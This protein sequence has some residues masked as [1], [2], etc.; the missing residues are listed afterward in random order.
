MMAPITKL[1]RK[2]VEWEWTTAQEKAFETVKAALT[3]KPLLRYPNFS[4]PFRLATGASAIGLGACLMQDYGQDWQPIAFASK[5]NN[6]VESKYSITELECLAVVWA[7][8]LFRPYLYGRTFTILTDHAALKW[9]M[10]S[11]NLTGKL[12]RWAITL[13]EYEF[14]VQFRPGSTNVVADALSRAPVKMLA[15]VGKRRRRRE[16][17]VI[18]EDESAGTP[19]VT[20]RLNGKSR[21]RYAT[22]R[23]ALK[24]TPDE[25]REV[26]R[27]EV[28][29]EQSTEATEGEAVTGARE[30]PRSPLIRGPRSI[31]RTEEGGIRHTEENE[32]TELRDH[33]L[34]QNFF[35]TRSAVC[36][37]TAT[38]TAYRVTYSTAAMTYRCPPSLMGSEPAT[39]NAH[40]S[41][42]SPPR[43]LRKGGMTSRGRVLRLPHSRH[44]LTDD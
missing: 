41:P 13:Q 36:S 1:L 40:R 7:I 24:K 18:N 2:S 31:Q 32:Y 43:R 30:L 11:N 19:K 9:L 25:S 37:S 35:A 16:Q 34:H 28:E 5:V 15:A 23:E 21:K 22:R 10:T 26:Q 39:S 17:V 14:D 8:K 44:P 38:A 33:G 4:L 6:E 12:H 27:Y 20:S 3:E 29:Y 42:T